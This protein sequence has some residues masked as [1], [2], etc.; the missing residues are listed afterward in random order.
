M[1]QLVDRMECG[2]HQDDT[3][4]VMQTIMCSKQLRLQYSHSWIYSIQLLLVEDV[5]SS[6]YTYLCRRLASSYIA[7]L[8]DALSLY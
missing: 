8:N 7:K 1:M 5:T 4:P 2:V 3:F 6:M